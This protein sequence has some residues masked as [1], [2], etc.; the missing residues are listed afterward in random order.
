MS[1]PAANVL[2]GFDWS[3]FTVV[4]VDVM[5]NS[6]KWLVDVGNWEAFHTMLLDVCIIQLPYLFI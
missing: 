2:N 6:N 5:S 4:N 3:K 1:V